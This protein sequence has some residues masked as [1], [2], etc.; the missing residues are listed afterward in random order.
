MQR[1]DNDTLECLALVSF[2]II[3]RFIN[4]TLQISYFK[5]VISAS[6]IS[7]WNFKILCE[8]F[9]IISITLTFK[10][11]YAMA[12]SHYLLHVLTWKPSLLGI[13][14]WDGKS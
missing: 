6:Y 13:E 2:H 4:F 5:Q 12:T 14:C 9:S 7:N 10:H 8:H 1:L 3:M 11:N